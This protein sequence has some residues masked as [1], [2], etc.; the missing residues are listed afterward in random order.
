MFYDSDFKKLYNIKIIKK[1]LK[2]SFFKQ[3]LSC[4]KK[5]T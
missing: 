3:I 2:K 1:M 5:Y 4:F